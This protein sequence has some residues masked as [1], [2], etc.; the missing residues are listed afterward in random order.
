MN[1]ET[2]R[3]SVLN[4]TRLMDRTSMLGGRRCGVFAFP[5]LVFISYCIVHVCCTAF[6]SCVKVT[7]ICVC[8]SVI[9]YDYAMCTAH[10]ESPMS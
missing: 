3:S 7:I 8:M 1:M 9:V 2:P 10:V 4:S 5:F 6:V